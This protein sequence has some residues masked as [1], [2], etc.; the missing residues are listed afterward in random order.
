MKIYQV[1]LF[2]GKNWHTIQTYANR[3]EAET[4]AQL[5]EPE[6]DVKEVSIEEALA[7]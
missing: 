4:F 1:R 3:S 7:S 5:L 2:N 6:W